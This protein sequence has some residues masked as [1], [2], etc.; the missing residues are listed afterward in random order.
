MHRIYRYSNTDIDLQV[1][2]LSSGMPTDT[3]IFT[4]EPSATTKLTPDL[5]PSLSWNGDVLILFQIISHVISSITEAEIV[6][7]FAN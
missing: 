3:A 2:K 7:V 5:D 6:A 1:F 4:F